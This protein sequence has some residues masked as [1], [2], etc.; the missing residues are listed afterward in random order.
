MFEDPQVLIGM[1][2]GA[3]IVIVG[4]TLGVMGHRK[5]ERD[6]AGERGARR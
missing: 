6:A 3:F 4:T 2:I 1:A 5:R